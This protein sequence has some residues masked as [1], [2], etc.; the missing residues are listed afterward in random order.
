MVSD[1]VRKVLGEIFDGSGGIPDLQPKQPVLFGSFEDTIALAEL[2]A[3]DSS[4]EELQRLFTARPQILLGAFGYA[5][6]TDLAFLTKP[7]IGTQFRA[8]FAT[9]S[10]DQG[11]CEV[12]LVEIERAEA[13]LFTRADTPARD[14]QTAMGQVRDWDQWIRQNQHTFIRDLIDSCEQLP[15]FPNRADNGGF[16]LVAP[17]VL[18]GAWRG[19]GGFDHP[20]VRYSILI[21]RWSRLSEAHRQRLIY[22][23]RHDNAVHQ[24]STYDQVARRSYVRPAVYYY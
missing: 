23:N 12:H 1:D 8:D 24:I 4:E 20:Q 18:E 16:R 19:F 13:T 11:G 9:L 15:L 7:P 14:L 6:D 21:G 17:E 2:L 22:M 5:Q 3:G 10:Y